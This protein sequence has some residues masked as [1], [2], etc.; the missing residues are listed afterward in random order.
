MIQMNAN[1]TPAPEPYRSAL[2]P[3]PMRITQQQ[4]DEL[5]RLRGQTGIPIQEHVRRALD[6][7]ISAHP[8]E[9]KRP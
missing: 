6:M 2:I 3:L 8:P 9:K 7:Y 1:K 5:E 4:R